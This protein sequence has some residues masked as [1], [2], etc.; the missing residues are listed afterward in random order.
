MKTVNA[1]AALSAGS[2][3]EPFQYQL[4][5]I[6]PK[7]IDIRVKFCGIC[8]SDLSMLHNH[9]GMTSYPFVPGHEVVGVVEEIGSEVQNF[10][11]GQKV[12]LG[13]FSGSC[14][15]C[16]TC[17]RGDH[18]MCNTAEQTIV[19]R[20]GGFA[21]LVRGNE[22]WVFPL[23]ENLDHT[24]VAPLFCGGITVFNPIVQNNILPIHKVG[25]IAIGGLGH[26]A[27][28]FLK[29]WGCEVFAFT[30]NV[31]KEQEIKQ[32]GAHH[33]LNSRDPEILKKLENSLDLVLNTANVTLD[34]G[35][36]I[37]M[38]KPRGVFHT[39]GVPL[40]PISAQAFALISKQRSISGTPLGSPALVE[41]MLNFSLRHNI[42][43]TVEY[44]KMNRVNEALQHLESGKARYRIILDND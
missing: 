7:Q 18:N 44:F 10:K 4:G 2:Q 41:D 42:Y 11:V 28:K 1:Y 23:P 6:G 37:N 19:G 32:M 16:Q 13:W 33:V 22:E 27:I 31:E 20:Y 14:M 29:A 8:H 9:W 40:E 24:K 34:W 35:L 5:K 12:G 30:S 25:V 21:D 26:M 17:M 43:P 3:L 39:V 38:L 15:R 36:Y